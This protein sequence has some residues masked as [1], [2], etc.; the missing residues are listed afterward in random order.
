MKP[1]WD[2]NRRPPP[3]P[4]LFSYPAPDI[5][6]RK[7]RPCPSLLTPPPPPPPCLSP[8][9]GRRRNCFGQGLLLLLLWFF[10]PLSPSPPPPAARTRVSKYLGKGLPTPQD[11]TAGGR[12]LRRGELALLRQLAEMALPPFIKLCGGA[13]AGGM[14]RSR[15]YSSVSVPNRE[16]RGGADVSHGRQIFPQIGGEPLFFKEECRQKAGEE[17]GKKKLWSSFL[18][19]SSFPSPSHAIVPY[20]E[21]RPSSPSAGAFLLPSLPAKQRPTNA[22]GNK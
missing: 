12:R 16:R 7:V 13:A 4:P 2:E 3:P 15:M 14:P 9:L 10:P 11:W 21:R 18:G 8:P 20:L 1:S 17:E 19:S 22:A 6:P 5:G